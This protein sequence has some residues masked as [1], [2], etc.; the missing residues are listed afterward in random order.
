M[1]ATGAMPDAGLRSPG[2]LLGVL[3]AHAALALGLAQI[4]L[5]PQRLPEPIL[6]ALLPAPPPEPDVQAR[7]LPQAE[8]TPPV[9]RVSMPPV[10]PVPPATSVPTPVAP[11]APPEEPVAVATTPAQP[12][13]IERAPEPEP[14]PPLRET[15]PPVP[16]L[17]VPAVDTVARPPAPVPA[18]V[19]Q[20]PAPPQP[21]PAPPMVQE[22]PATQPLYSADYLRNPKPR[23]PLVSRR[24]GEEGLVMLRVFVTSSGEPTQVE[25]K[26]SCGFPRLDQAAQDVVKSWRFVPARRGESP[27]DA[28]VLVPIRFT[29]KG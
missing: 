18:P 24:M 26:E 17:S 4:V 23:Y 28:W 11:L 20:V 27:V 21:Q 29:L 5:Q 6:V 7:P 3:A 12:P 15:A 13:P 25:L 22:R 9:R 8:V 10:Q 2:A 14:P 16:V 19:A 1:T